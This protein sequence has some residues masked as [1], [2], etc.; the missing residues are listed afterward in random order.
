MTDGEMLKLITLGYGPV[1]ETVAQKYGLLMKRWAY[2][3]VRNSWDA[4][5]CVNESLMILWEAAPRYSELNLP[6]FLKTIVRRQAFAMMDYRQAKKRCG[7]TECLED[8]DV[9]DGKEHLRYD[10]LALLKT[11]EKFLQSV[12][13]LHGD[14]LILRFYYGYSFK[15]IS[16][17]TGMTEPGVRSYVCRVKPQIQEFLIREGYLL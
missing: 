6:A 4:E 1:M 9:C 7:I 16:I 3:V 8:Y 2:D 17:R 11:V 13:A 14:I 15:Q 5:E 10:E 12:S